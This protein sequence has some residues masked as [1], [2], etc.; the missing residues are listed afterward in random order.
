MGKRKGDDPDIAEVSTVTSNISI[1]TNDLQ[2]TLL[3]SSSVDRKLWV[4]RQAL[5]L[6]NNDNSGEEIVEHEDDFIQEVQQCK[7]KLSSF[8]TQKQELINH[9][10][11][12][13]GKLTKNIEK[14]QSKCQVESNN[15]IAL[16][17]SLQAMVAERDELVNNMKE[18]E[19]MSQEL[20][21]KIA[22]A[23]RDANQEVEAIDIV[24]ENRK[25]QVPKLKHQISLYATTTGIKWDFENDDLLQG[26]VV[27]S[28]K[29]K[30]FF[31]LIL[32]SKYWGQQ[33]SNESY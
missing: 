15:V 32:T 30:I 18:L 29:K 9:S 26:H 20:Q 4:I 22:L 28:E 10:S 23:I 3:N 31:V 33:N 11:Q 5:K 8:E 17:Q 19:Q 27:C 12:M 6:N 14:E 21:T 25:N 2:P 24:E 16:E 13:K 7:E 1:S